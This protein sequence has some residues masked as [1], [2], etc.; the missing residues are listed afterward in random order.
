MP[1]AAREHRTEVAHHPNTIL[2]LELGIIAI[3]WVFH[4]CRM[5]HNGQKLLVFKEFLKILGLHWFLA[6]FI[7]TLLWVRSQNVS[8]TEFAESV[9]TVRHNHGLPLIQSVVVLAP[10]ALQIILHIINL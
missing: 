3:A 9:A 5:F 2:S 4:L 7:W 10:F 1:G 6:V 8:D